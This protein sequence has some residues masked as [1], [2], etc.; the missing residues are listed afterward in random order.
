MNTKN[1]QVTDDAFLVLEEALKTA[2]RLCGEPKAHRAV[3]YNRD[4]R[5]LVMEVPDGVDQHAQAGA[6]VEAEP[7]PEPEPYPELGLVIETMSSD[8]AMHLD[9]PV[10]ECPERACAPEHTTTDGGEQ[11]TAPA[12]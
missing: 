4:H 3:R 5:M 10:T 6:L 1:I 11:V 9:H 8:Q 7:Y 12:S 2:V